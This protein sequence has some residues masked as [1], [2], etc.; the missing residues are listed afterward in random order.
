MASEIIFEVVG[1]VGLITLNRSER[2]NAFTKTMAYELIETFDQVNNDDAIRSVVV[3]GAGRGFCAGADLV[4]G[5]KTFD[6]SKDEAHSNGKTRDTGGKV[7]LAIFQ[8]KKPIVGAINGPAVGIGVT[9]TLPMD[10][11][12]AS[13]KAKFGFVFTRRGVVPEAASS[14]FL[15]RIVGISQAL[16]WVLSGRVFDAQEALAGNLVSEVIEPDL[17]IDRALERANQMTLGT[18]P[19]SVALARQM[20][21]TMMGAGSPMDA[22]RLDS[23]AMVSRGRSGDAYEGIESFLQKREPNFMDLVSV[24]VPDLIP[25]LDEF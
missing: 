19:V 17:L 10:L 11:R 25:K 13:T 12:I 9:M 21:W 3:T 2:L 5:G 15:P 4:G 8:S 22:H 14:W 1:K 20:L 24:D 23:K 16:D 7:S 18:S 6:Y